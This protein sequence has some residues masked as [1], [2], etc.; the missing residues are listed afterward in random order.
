M[1]TLDNTINYY[2]LLMYY[3]DTSV[4]KEYLLPDGFHYAFYKNGD[5]EDWVNI[6]IESGEFTSIE[7][8]L[9]HFHDFYDSFINELD[10]RCVFI[11]DDATLEKVGTATISLLEKEEFGYKAAV[12]WVAIKKKYQGMGLAR[13]LISKFIQIANELNHKSLILH[14]QTTTWL[15]C[16]LYL[17]FGFEILNKEE[18]NGWGILR[19]LTDHDKLIE[20]SYVSEEDVYDKRNIEIEKQLSRLYGTD[21]FNYSVWYKNGEHK[22]YVYS[23]KT[24][25][26]FEYFIVKDKLILKEVVDK[27][28][29]R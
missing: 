5:E 16:K 20:F 29:K 13:P 17:E 10:R 28:Y 1:K 23:N 12:D 15:A 6:H 11:V 3:S 18:V 8:G 22:V 26:E 7:R 19:T 4:Y 24:P 9:E 21:N 27:T 14:T 25:Y 2:E